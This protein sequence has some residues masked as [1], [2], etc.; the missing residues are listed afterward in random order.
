MYF[1]RA[2]SLSD[3]IKQGYIGRIHSP[4]YVALEDQKVRCVVCPH[5][6]E[7]EAG[8]RGLCQVRANIDGQYFSLVYANP[9]AVHIDPTEKRPFYHVLP[10]SRSFS[11]Y[12]NTTLT[13]P[14]VR[15][16]RT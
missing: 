10:A 16:Q 12:R 13:N 14:M 11:A 5:T 9:C 2:H 4:Y 15:I 6:C 8:E 7:V 3:I 1:V